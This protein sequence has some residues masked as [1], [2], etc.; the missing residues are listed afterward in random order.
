MMEENADIA[1]VTGDGK[2]YVVQD[3]HLWNLDPED[4][5]K[6]VPELEQVQIVLIGTRL[7]QVYSY[8]RGDS[9]ILVVN[10]KKAIV[11]ILKNYSLGQ[12]QSQFIK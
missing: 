10:E 2:Y 8:L 11:G 5:V 9:A 12:K 3:Y 1:V 4:V 7:N 6:N